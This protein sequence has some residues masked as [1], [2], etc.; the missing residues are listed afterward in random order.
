M[1][2]KGFNLSKTDAV[3]ENVLITG[4]GKTKVLGKDFSLQGHQEHGQP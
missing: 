3:L 1:I 4:T 2:A